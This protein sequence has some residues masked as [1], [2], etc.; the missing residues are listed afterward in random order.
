MEE[1]VSLFSVTIYF[2]KLEGRLFQATQ[3]KQR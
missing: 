2:T 3:P 1:I